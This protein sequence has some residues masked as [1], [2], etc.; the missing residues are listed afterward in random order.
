[1][2]T[3]QPLPL[4]PAFV[5]APALDSV[6]HLDLFDLCAAMPAGSVDMILCDLPY[7]TTACSWDTIIPFAP[8][9]TAFKRII[10]PR[11]AIV[12][13]ASQPFTSALVMSNVGM[14]RYCWYWYKNIVSNFV[15]AAHQPT[16]AIEEICVFYSSE[17][18]YNPQ[19]TK[20]RIKDRKII[21]GRP[22]GANTERRESEHAYGVKPK[23]YFFPEFI[24]P[25]NVLEIPCVP[26]AT[27]SLHPTQKPVALFR[28]LIRTYTRPG[29]LVF[30]P[31]V[32]SGTTAVAAREE[33]RRFV[34]GDS[35]AEYVQVA[36][37]R[38][39]MPWTPSFMPLL[40]SA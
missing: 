32:G 36:R 40:D 7:G 10:K 11:G 20:S 33:G 2:N 17:H 5:S 3:T 16:R 14:F 24:A 25:Y 38:L 12:L 19:P 9:W 8:M 13:T 35:S 6:Y 30:D 18:V 23:H 31:C 27:G 4:L 1:M 37:D 21:V 29:E 34:V 26:R 22:N 15:N 28:Y 39:A